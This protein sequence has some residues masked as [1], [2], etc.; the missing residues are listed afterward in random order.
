MCTS[1]IRPRNTTAPNPVMTPTISASSESGKRRKRR[2]DSSIGATGAGGALVNVSTTGAAIRFR[3][4]ECH[5]SSL[6]TS[7]CAHQMRGPNAVIT[8]GLRCG[9][10]IDGIRRFTATLVG[11]E[12]LDACRRILRRQPACPALA[13]ACNTGEAAKSLVQRPRRPQRHRN[14]APACCL[15]SSTRRM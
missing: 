7:G 5:L 1:P 4:R 13:T 3:G 2:T 10:P 15:K 12:E 6:P 9:K 11:G 14:P 8:A